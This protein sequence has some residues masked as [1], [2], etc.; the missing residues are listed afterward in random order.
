MSKSY[1]E[2]LKVDNIIRIKWRPVEIVSNSRAENVW[3]VCIKEENAVYRTDLQASGA[4][5]CFQAASGRSSQG[6]RQTGKTRGASSASGCAAAAHTGHPLQ[7]CKGQ[8]LRC[9]CWFLAFYAFIKW[10][11]SVG[12]IHR[13]R[14]PF[15]LSLLSRQWGA[16]AIMEASVRRQKPH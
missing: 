11:I 4:A 9:V 14:F 5:Q 7:R 13:I 12:V 8:R 2:T 3:N 16:W 15:F 10:E 6:S 1:W